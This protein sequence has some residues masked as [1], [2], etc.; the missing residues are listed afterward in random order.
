MV[1]VGYPDAGGLIAILAIYP[2]YR[3][4]NIYFLYNLMNQ[5]LGNKAFSHSRS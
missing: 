1:L 5:N 4:G 2:P 3:G